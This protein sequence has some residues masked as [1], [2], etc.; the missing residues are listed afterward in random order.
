MSDSSFEDSVLLQVTSLANI[1]E[2]LCGYPPIMRRVSSSSYQ[3]LSSVFD[4]KLGP[5][6]DWF[7]RVETS[8]LVPCSIVGVAARLHHTMATH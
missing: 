2:C 8:S 7:S 4:H 1:Y 3:V 5:W 6:L